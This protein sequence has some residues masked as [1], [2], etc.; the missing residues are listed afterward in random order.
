MEAYNNIN[1]LTNHHSPKTRPFRASSGK[2]ILSLI[3]EQTTIN[4]RKHTFQ[5]EKYL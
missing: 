3:R 1:H 4:K 2:S 5:V